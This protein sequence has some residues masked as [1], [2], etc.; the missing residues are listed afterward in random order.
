MS[1]SRRNVLV[2]AAAAGILAGGPKLLP[3]LQSLPD[4]VPIEA[5]PGYQR[6][7]YAGV[8]GPS[9]FLG[10]DAPTENT[11]TTSLDIPLREALFG[12]PSPG[13]IPVAVFTDVQ[14]PYCRVLSELLFK[15]SK[16]SP[17]ISLTWHELPLL[18]PASQ[19]AARAALA[20]QK[21]NAYEA[22]H[23]RLMRSQF[24]PS[25]AYLQQLALD[26]GIDPEQL[27]ADRDSTDVTLSLNRSAA[28]A[29]LFSIPGTPAMVIDRTLVIGAI[30][31]PLVNRL[32]R[33]AEPWA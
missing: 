27:L 6:I 23:Q 21:Q 13:K 19:L 33:R 3:Y 10:L 31:A 18:G 25:P 2:L 1:L 32:I 15:R 7:D 9:A 20:A 14:C 22:F 24:R 8:T 5:L 12:P 28:L 11:D 16:Q 30:P 29:R 4:A 17:A 26:L